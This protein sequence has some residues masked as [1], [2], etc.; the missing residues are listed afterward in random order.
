MDNLNDLKAI[1][2]TADTSK[3]PVADEIKAISKSYRQKALVKKA[4]VFAATLVSSAIFV[5][6][7]FFYHPFFI[8]TRIGQGF[9]LFAMLVLLWSN[10][11]SLGRIYKIRNCSNQE[12]LKYLREVQI[13][14]IVY[15]NKTQVLCMFFYSAGLF[16]YLY[17]MVYKNIYLGIGLYL[18]T[19][20][21]LAT[22]W[23]YFRPRAY[24]RQKEKFEPMLNH[25]EKLNKQLQQP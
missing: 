12:F 11:K 22:S 9:I 25:I 14:R 21:A 16:L 18:L 1:W 10:L 15:Y 2:Q 4:W 7:L 23:L 5:V 3:L 8:S 17:E 20:L 19:I 13:N 6:S 24:Q